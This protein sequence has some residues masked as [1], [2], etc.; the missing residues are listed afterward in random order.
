MPLTKSK[1]KKIIL[2]VGPTAIGKTD[3]SVNI[4][5]LLKTDI[6]SFDSRQFYK[7]LKIGTAPPTKKQLN[8]VKHHFIH[9]ISIQQEYNVGKYEKEALDL[10]NS[11]HKNKE[12]IVVVGGSGLYANAI[13]HGLD[14]IPETN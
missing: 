4:A 7:E 10:I 13:T 6:I 9:H 1:K 11:L 5:K 14:N 12:S 2:I 3:L 8:I